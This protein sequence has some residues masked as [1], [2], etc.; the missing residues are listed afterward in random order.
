MSWKSRWS[1]AA[2][3]HPPDSWGKIWKNDEMP[4]QC[5]TCEIPRSSLLWSFSQTF[6]EYLPVQI[7]KGDPW[8]GAMS[9]ASQG[10]T[11]GLSL[12]TGPFPAT[13]QIDST[14]LTS[15]T[16]QL[17]NPMN[18]PCACASLRTF[19][20]VSIKSCC[21][22]R[23]AFNACNVHSKF[24]SSHSVSNCKIENDHKLQC[25]RC[26]HY[27]LLP[28]TSLHRECDVKV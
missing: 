15:P 4:S 25:W 13:W 5:L 10:Y 8:I 6:S 21:Q 12:G 16:H 2:N 14:C 9:S 1:P 24:R 28:L 20:L 22:G 26:Q 18:Q 17:S 11:L 27:S 3:R 7:L 19:N 23:S